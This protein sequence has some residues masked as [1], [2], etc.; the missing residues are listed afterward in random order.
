MVEPVYIRGSV[1]VG[2]IVDCQC[3]SCDDGQL[4]AGYV[5]AGCISREEALPDIPLPHPLTSSRDEDPTP[6]GPVPPWA[7][8]LAEGTLVDRTATGATPPRILAP[9]RFAPPGLP[10]E[11]EQT[12]HNQPSLLT[13]LGANYSREI[14]RAARVGDTTLLEKM[15]Q[16]AVYVDY[17]HAPAKGA[18]AEQPE[19]VIRLL[20]SS[21]DSGTGETLL[22]AA[23]KH[24][25]ALAVRVLLANSADP[26]AVD[27]R[28]RMALHRAAEGG[29]VL[30]TLMILD[31]LQTANRFVT[32]RD[33]V[34]NAGET[35]GTLAATMGCNAVCGALEV[36]GDMQLNAEQQYFG[37]LSGSN[38]ARTAGQMPGTSTSLLGAI[39]ITSESSEDRNHAKQV[40]REATLG[41]RLVQQLWQH[42]PEDR[43]SL[44]RVLS[45]AFDGLRRVEEL[46]LCTCWMPTR[47]TT[48]D[49]HWKGFAKTLD[50]RARWQRIRFE[51]TKSLASSEVEEFWQTHLSAGRMAQMTTTP[52]S[53]RQLFLGVLW[54][55]TRESWLPHVMDAVAGVL[56]ALESEEAASAATAPFPF[57]EL[58]EAL[59]PM[60]QLVQAATCFFRSS[61]VRHE[62]ITFRPLVLSSAALQELI[63]TYLASKDEYEK[64][65]VSQACVEN[66]A[67]MVPALD[68]GALWF[69][70]S[71]GSFATS[72]ASRW[73]A[74][75]RLVQTN[76]NVLLAIQA[77]SRS[78]SYPEHMSLRGGSDDVSPSEVES[79]LKCAAEA[80]SKCDALI[81][82]AGAGM[83]VDSGLPDFRGSTGL[84]KD[85]SVAMSYEEMSDDKW[86]SEDPL[87]A[88][89]INY[90][91]IRR[92]PEMGKKL[93]KLGGTGKP[94]YVWTSNIDGMFEKVGFP[95]ELIYACHGDLH[96][97]QCTKDRRT[98]KGLA[99][100]G[101]DEV[102]SA[103]V[104]PK[105]LDAEVDE[106]AL[107]FRSAESLERSCFLC[108]RCG[109]LARPNVWFCH[110]KNYN[111]SRASIERGNGFNKWL[112]ELQDRQAAV[113]VIECGGGLAIPS[114]RV[115]G[116][117]AVEGSGK[118][119]LLVRLNPVHCKVPAERGVGIPL[120]SMEGLLRLDAEVER[121]RGRKEKV[122]PARK[123]IYPSGT[124][125]RLL[126]LARTTSSDLEPQACPAGSHRQWSV[127]VI[128]LVATDPRPEA[129]LLLDQWSGL[130]QLEELLLAWA[131]ETNGG[132]LQERLQ[133]A[134]ALLLKGGGMK[135]HWLKAADAL[136]RRQEEI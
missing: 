115:Q 65:V 129:F 63:D 119:S 107:R 126:R 114:V 23:A 64:V 30:S 45:K 110:D 90:T 89:G 11:F 134:M 44:D 102:W 20:S 9:T 36:F 31:R 15:I 69:T 4:D 83:G 25:E 113:V 2:R 84:F 128:E 72:Y 132:H 99:P 78:P 127:T 3:N 133:H 54:L 104:I 21:R 62:G 33:F 111:V 75:R 112:A 56:R 74:G 76:A 121:L 48:L 100:D 12:N 82:T 13:A 58:I 67:A 53:L 66:E 60:A 43:E 96:H 91:Q 116:E 47:S 88:W 37:Q 95:P 16:D 1:E 19:D 68:T 24:G 81:F 52:G 80:I 46:L 103:E 40:L 27:S 59:S 105:D 26:A 39:K 93:G 109:R 131:E 14:F 5:W 122:S 108:S 136:R 118:G 70:L 71:Q 57:D 106:G 85:R 51:A 73:D 28:G 42:I 120:G 92:S 49:A 22:G 87:F 32:V 61:G 18:N 50:L 8:A 77:D 101:S 79:A 38:C 97:L 35:P 98:C 41:G 125:F 135:L 55:Y 17:P 124:L 34:D 94:Y 7:V 117:D 10:E 123:A 6:R 86:F 29:D 130:Q